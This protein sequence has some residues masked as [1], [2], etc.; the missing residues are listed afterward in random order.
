MEK[1]ATSTLSPGA[2]TRDMVDWP[3]LCSMLVN[4]VGDT[5]KTLFH[6]PRKAKV[7]YLRR[8]AI[9]QNWKSSRPHGPTGNPASG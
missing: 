3:P 9:V 5:V 1:K 6:S 2:P 8:G 7:E 4:L